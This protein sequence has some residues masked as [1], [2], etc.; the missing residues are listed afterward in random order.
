MGPERPAMLRASLAAWPGVCGARR[1]RQGRG[2]ALSVVLK[3]RPRLRARPGPGTRAGWWSRASALKPRAAERKRLLASPV[4]AAEAFPL[5]SRESD[6]R[7]RG[8]E[9]PPRR[10]KRWVPEKRGLRGDVLLLV[11]LMRREKGR[12]TGR[13]RGAEAPKLGQNLEVV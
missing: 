7:R 9:S 11:P 5:S 1:G 10:R 2:L 3:P 12:L 13:W 8:A 6:R 4:G